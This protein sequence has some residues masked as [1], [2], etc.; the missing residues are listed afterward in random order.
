MSRLAPLL[1]FTRSL[2]VLKQTTS[3]LAV[4]TKQ[5]YALGTDVFSDDPHYLLPGLLLLRDGAMTKENCSGGSEG[6]APANISIS[7]ITNTK[8]EASL[9]ATNVVNPC[10]QPRLEIGEYL[11]DDAIPEKDKDRLR[12]LQT[13]LASET[14]SKN[15]RKRLWKEV[16]WVANRKRRNDE[17]KAE[18]KKRQSEIRE[19]TR[20]PSQ[21]RQRIVRMANSVCKVRVALDLSVHGLMTDAER[22]KAGKQTQRCYAMNRRADRPLQLYLT[23]LEGTEYWTGKMPGFDN[24]D[25]HQVKSNH[26]EHFGRDQVVYLSGDSDTELSEL[27]DSEVYIIGCMVDHNRLKGVTY[28]R[29]LDAGVRHARLPLDR[30]VDMKTRKVL[31]ID[32]CFEI[33]LN[34]VN[35]MTWEEAIIRAI[36]ARKGAQLKGDADGEE[37]SK[38]EKRRNQSG[39]AEETSAETKPSKELKCGNEKQ[40]N[41]VNNIESAAS[42][43]VNKTTESIV[44][45]DT[46]GSETIVPNTKVRDM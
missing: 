19:G 33:L 43:M 1:F 30:Y 13:E 46:C 37:D 26:V 38:G 6:Q 31:T 8:K 39:D 36:P 35:G 45:G 3:A 15:R 10:E 12:E 34:R 29:A 4:F 40:E 25:V 42:E 7:V 18:R 22:M 44:I 28:Q 32:H 20:E 11:V 2:R 9:M 24:W 5:C 16:E 17:K 21:K 27:V 14:I 23:G 41:V